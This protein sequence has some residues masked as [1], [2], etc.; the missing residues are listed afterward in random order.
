MS[1]SHIEQAA[2]DILGNMGYETLFGPDI[3]PDGR[4]PERKSY[5]DV[6]LTERLER[7]IDRLNPSIPK[8]AQEEA[9]KK[10]LRTYS[11]YLI[12]NNKEFHRY[13]VN[14]VPV[15][16][17]K[18]DRIKNDIV[19]IFDFENPEA[20]EFLAVN[21][22]TVIENEYNKR[23]DIVLFINGLP[24]VVI[25]LKNPADEKTT[26]WTAFNKLQ[27][28]KQEIPS[29]FTYN[30]ALIVSDGTEARAGALTS[31]KEWFLPWKTID[32]ET[33][34][35]KS[36]P[37]L[38]IL[39]MGMLDKTRLLDIV[40]NFIVFREGKKETS[41]VIAAYHQYHTTNKAVQ[42]TI[43]AIKKD[44]RIGIVWH[45][46][47]SGKSLTM[48]FYSGKLVLNKGLENPTIV[49]ITDRNDLDDQLFDTFS[50]CKDLL[51]Q[52][53][54]QAMSRDEL[55][56]FLH[57]ASGGVVFTTIQKFFP[58]NKGES[59][60]ALSFRKNIIV[61]ADEA[62]RSQYDF[63]DGFARHMR[64]ALPN[65]SFIGFTGTPIELSDKSTRNVFGDY[66]DIY[67]IEQAVEDGATVR[68]FYE[69]R[70]A[71]LEL[72][73]SN[74]PYIDPEF[75]EVTESEEVYRK[76]KL[77]SKWARLE[78]IVGSEKRINLIAKDIIEHF[79]KREE[80]LE[81]KIMIVC[82]SRRICVDIYNAISK[83]RPQWNSNSDNEGIMK[84]IM[85]GAPEDPVDW[86]KHIRN[87]LKRQELATRFK[88]PNDKFIIAIV[89]DMW[90][91]GFDVPSLHTMYIDK[92]MRGHGLMQTIAR[93]NRVFKDKPG[94]LI[95]DYLGLAYELKKALS[96]YTESG[97]RGEPV[98]DQEAAVKVMKEKYEIV[99]AMFY[100]FDYKK[101]FTGTPQEKMAVI[102]A[103]IEHIL[104]QKDGKERLLKYVTELSQAFALS[105][106]NNEA[107]KIRDNVAFFQ[108]VRSA[109]AK[110]TP[111][112]GKTIDDLDFAIK[113]IVSK[114]ISTDKVIDIFAV[115]G[116]KKPDISILSDE[117][118]EEIKG[119]KQKN[120]AFEIL[121]K[122]LNDE[123]K[124]SF[125]RNIVQARS[126]AKML[127]ETIKKYQ[128]RTIETAQ[129]IAQLIDLAKDFREAQKRGEK[130]NLSE[131]ELAF[132]DA[133]TNNESAIEVLGNETLKKIA[134]ELTI[135]IRE[136][137]T[138]DWTLKDSVKA[139]LRVI[140]KRQLRK[141]GYPPDKRE[142]ATKLI[143]E[144]A[145]LISE[146]YINE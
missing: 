22:F 78:A 63:I 134:R 82:M 66:I 35:P 58:E 9:I 36:E 96:T 12:E 138:I 77:K 72:D 60:S 103:A 95:V 141:Y 24:L 92:P 133:L 144:Q 116:I 81:G 84:V 61:I 50:V 139:N 108:T 121:K 6:V 140:V 34:A 74:K 44:R 18:D 97:G 102:P 79:E 68:I 27:T 88:N 113:Q 46:Q 62:H 127:E 52:K 83:L 131:D 41:K 80:A 28:Y 29:L 126:F 142:E 130:L 37:Q 87:K 56:Q 119:M 25:E 17:R 11:P 40:K 55:K 94:G 76:E 14:G 107:I 136:N 106:P 104:E 33:L 4:T 13:L 26:I 125:K 23:P 86:Q 128:N 115:A 98:L 146:N 101:F 32:G 30:E 129:V 91:T 143:M 5:K 67:D 8:D 2:L 111:P 118:L 7:V 39:L 42:S 120:L 123:I 53:P 15:E 122:L 16:Y 114:A 85:T 1:E 124:V 110:I 10:I 21:Q 93:V 71:K 45:T 109:L 51:R 99:S 59:Y 117:F 48:V 38:K 3:A 90:L 89:R 57:V 75:E 49:V 54:V 65:A 31:N 47:G 69:S 70:L 132:Y 135:L 64:D 137:T 145:T 112:S 105:V 43:E 100:G 73:E 19:K 20:N